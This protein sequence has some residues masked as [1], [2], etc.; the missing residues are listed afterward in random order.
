MELEI[1]YQDDYI[2]AINKPHG[3][4]VH[5]SPI[6]SDVKVFAMQTLRNQLDRHVFP[7]H[8]IDRKTSG[9]LLFAFS[10]EI[11]TTF[12]KLFEEQ[13]IT[14]EYEA[15]VRGW[16]PDK[17]SSEREIGNDKGVKQS[18]STTFSTIE[19]F[20]KNWVSTKYPTSRY[21]HILAFPKT[22]RYH[23]IRKHL[24]HLSFPIICD[25]PHG[26]KDQNRFFKQTFEIST[27]PLHARKLSFHHPYLNKQICIEAP[28]QP[29]FKKI[30]AL[31]KEE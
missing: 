21:S 24:N 7:V 29:E 11:L 22:G 14:K 18:A 15:I 19:T 27:M 12:S 17:F 2:V 4:L 9:I 10:K 1:V 13:K 25:R 31:L 16:T 3:L 6:A 20:E 26:C 28:L 8:R 5:R 30:L 23:Q